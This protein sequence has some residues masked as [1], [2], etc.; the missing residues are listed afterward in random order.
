MTAKR[1]ALYMKLVKHYIP[2]RI[3]YK[4]TVKVIKG[5]DL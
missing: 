1:N 2:R 3:A 5:K 4:I